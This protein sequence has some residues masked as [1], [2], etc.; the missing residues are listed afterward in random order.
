MGSGHRGIGW[1]IA[2]A[3]VQT[4]MSATVV[5][6]PTPFGATRDGISAQVYTLRSDSGEVTEPHAL[7][8]V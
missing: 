1:L 6:G 5:S 2:L 3:L 7:T 8:S 4:G